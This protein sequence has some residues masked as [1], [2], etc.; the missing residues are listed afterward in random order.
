MTFE[1]LCNIIYR[2]NSIANYVHIIRYIRVGFLAAWNNK[3]D[4]E[5]CAK[6]TTD[7][8]Q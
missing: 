7:K 1:S 5:E 6:W 2:N 8:H 3:I 4:L